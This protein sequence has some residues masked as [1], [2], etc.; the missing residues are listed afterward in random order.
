MQQLNE[1]KFRTTF[2]KFAYLNTEM[3]F[4]TDISILIHKSQYKNRTIDLFKLKLNA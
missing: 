1:I 3:I 2:Y 4:S